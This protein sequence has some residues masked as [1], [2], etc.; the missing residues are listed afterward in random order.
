MFAKVFCPT[1]QLHAYQIWLI[2]NV[3]PFSCVL[4]AIHLRSPKGKHFF[5]FTTTGLV[6]M[7]AAWQVSCNCVTVFHT[8]ELV[9]F[10]TSWFGSLTKFRR[11]NSDTCQADGTQKN[12]FFSPSYWNSSGYIFQ[13]PRRIV[14][15]FTI[16]TCCL[17]RCVIKCVRDEKMWDFIQMG[18][19]VLVCFIDLHLHSK[20]KPRIRS[21]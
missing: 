18:I 14:S 13:W 21:N 6:I 11:I 8:K 5:V 3:L 17:N 12:V 4:R 20:S 2:R 7:K 10:Q 15:L 16:E 19:F 9:R 1:M